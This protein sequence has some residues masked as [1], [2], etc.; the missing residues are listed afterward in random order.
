MKKIIYLLFIAVFPVIFSSC[1]DQP[2]SYAPNITGTRGEVTLVMPDSL[3]KSKV[4]KKITDILSKDQPGLPRSEPLFDVRFISESTFSDFF[5]T[6]RNIIKVSVSQDSKPTINV[7]HDVWAQ[8]QLVIQVNGPGEE[9][10]ASI[11]EEHEN[12]I[13]NQIREEE[14]KR[15][16]YSAKNSLNG[17]IIKTL[18][19]DH[20]INIPVPRGFEMY[21]NKEGF[22]WMGKEKTG[23]MLYIFI[24]YYNYTD[25]NTFT[26]EFLLNKRDSVMKK[27]V[28]GRVKGSYMTTEREFKKPVMDEF[29]YKGNY[30]AEIRGLW[31]MIEG[32]IMGG[33]FVNLATVDQERNRVVHLE[34]FVYAPNKEHRN[35]IRYLESII[36]NFEFIKD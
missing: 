9:E 28:E 30:V 7:K 26:K 35:L 10:I 22:A 17:D 36:Y 19:K 23:Q 11:I 31:K 8:H 15:S 3:Y 16:V 13:I 4:G 12:E 20:H 32:D 33:S 27:Y 14:R 34:G 1:Q 25:T 29:K 24:Y 21:V 2:N 6:K 5:Q 18:K